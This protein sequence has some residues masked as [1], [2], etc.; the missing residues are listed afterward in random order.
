MNV[1]I[2]VCQIPVISFLIH[3]NK[4]KASLFHHFYFSIFGFLL[5]FV[6]VLLIIDE[7]MV[8]YDQETKAILNLI[9]I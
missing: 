2:L 9:L 4:T 7:V 1:T 5:L 6:I 3:K 8:T